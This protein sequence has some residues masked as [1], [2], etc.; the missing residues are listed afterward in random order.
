MSSN[1]WRQRH[2]DTGHGEVLEAAGVV[3]GLN[4]ES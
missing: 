1:H 4:P 3:S 2:Y